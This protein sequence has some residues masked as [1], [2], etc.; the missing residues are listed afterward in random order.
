MFVRGIKKE[1]LQDAEA[2]SVS[3]QIVAGVNYK[4]IYEAP[5]GKWYEAIVFRQSWTSTTQLT[6]FKEVPPVISVGS[7]ASTTS[8]VSAATPPTATPATISPGGIMVG[9]YS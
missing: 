7:T 2:V 4:I 3:T 1:E 5:A 8:V 9:A 6:S